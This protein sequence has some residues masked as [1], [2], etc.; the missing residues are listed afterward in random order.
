MITIK[1]VKEI[2]SMG[3]LALPYPRLKKISINGSRGEAATPEAIKYAQAH[4][5]ALKAV[6]TKLRAFIS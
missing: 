5:K 2:L 3:G 6:D 1:E 4:Y